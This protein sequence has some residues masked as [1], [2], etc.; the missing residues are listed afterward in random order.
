MKQNRPCRCRVFTGCSGLS[1]SYNGGKRQWKASDE[2][3]SRSFDYRRF[4]RG[5]RVAALKNDVMNL[6]RNQDPPVEWLAETLIAMFEGKDR[7]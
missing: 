6:L 2:D 1:I 4:L 5:G 3:T 7:G